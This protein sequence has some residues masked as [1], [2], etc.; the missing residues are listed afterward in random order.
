MIPHNFGVSRPVPRKRA[1]WASLV[2]LFGLF[3]LAGCA[4]TADPVAPGKPAMPAL[5]SDPVIDVTAQPLQA[6]T[7][8]GSIAA[9]GVVEALEEVSVASELS[10]TVESIHVNEGDRVVAGQ[11]LLTL[12]A[13]KRELA[14]QQV[15]QQ[16]E[17]SR[18]ALKEARLKRDR[19]LDLARSESVSKEI[20]DS[21][22]LAVDGAEAAYQQA[23]AALA[24]AERELADTQIVSPTDGSVDVRAVEVGEPV[25]AGSALVTLQADTSLR[26][27][28]W[29][30]EADIAHLRAGSAAQVRSSSLPG[31]AFEARVEWVG[32]NADPRTG[33]FPVKLILTDHAQR[34]RPGMTASVTIEGVQVPDALM[35]PDSALVDRDRRRVVFVVEDGVARMREPLLAAGLSNRL[36]IIDGLFAGDVVVTSDQARL[37]EGSPVRIAAGP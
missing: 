9:F 35:L 36:L 16:V 2:L 13:R 30:S 34:L 5:S 32:V 8:Q 1:C 25:Q 12:D 22:R 19:R 24:L 4:D 27:Q 31:Q 15:K 17:R 6:Q 10:G 37:L 23:R 33:N 7:W 3:N 21:A 29:V 28:T 18:T 14:L 11:L 26:V 20:L